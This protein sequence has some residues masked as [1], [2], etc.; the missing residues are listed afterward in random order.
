MPTRRNAA[1]PARIAPRAA[2]GPP[3]FDRLDRRRRATDELGD[4]PSRHDHRVHA[5]TLQLDHLIARHGFR[6]R[7]RELSDRHVREQFERAL[8]IVRR[9]MKRLGVVPL[10]HASE[11]LLAADADDD[12]EPEVGCVRG[13]GVEP[14]SVLVVPLGDHEQRIRSRTI[15]IVGRPAAAPEDWQLGC[16]AD[17]CEGRPQDD[18]LGTVCLC[19]SCG[20]GRVDF[21]DHR[22]SVSLGYR[23]TKSSAAPLGQE[24]GSYRLRYRES[25]RVSPAF[26]LVIFALFVPAVATAAVIQGTARPDRLKGT[27]KAD[28]ID[29]VFGATDRVTCGKGVDV[30]TAD[31]ADTVARDCEFVSRRISTDT[32][33]ASAGQHQTE[34]EPSVAGWGSTAV[35]TFQVGRFTDGGATGIGWSTST[36]AG[37]TWRSGVLPALTSA[38]HPAG[39]APRASDPAVAYDAVHGTWLI[40][41]LVL[42]NGFTALGISRSVDG[43]SWSA[44]V[45]AARLSTSSLAYDKEWISCDNGPTSPFHGSCYLVYTDIASPRIALQVSRDGGATWS[46]PVTVTSAF[47]AGAEG[48]LPIVQPN[49]ALTLVFNAGDAGMYAV[50]STDGGATFAPPVGIAPISEAS[51]PLLR[52]PALPT[53][54]VDISGRIYVVWADCVFRP[55]CDGNTLVLTTSTDGSTWTGLRRLPGTGFDSFVPGLA[56]DPSMPGRLSIVTYV[57]NSTACSAATCSIG[58]AVTGSRDGGTSWSKPQRLDAVSPRTAWLAIAERQFVGDYVGAAF[59]AGRFVPV[60]ALASKPLSGG[61]LREY[62]MAASLS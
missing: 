5:A 4:V 61:R 26:T 30:V 53:A 55:G 62:M 19:G 6:F 39:E 51:Q 20:V 1:A 10:E 23:L 24:C 56:A 45:F 17:A 28:R 9:E 29:A 47:G 43:L 48:A 58:V 16:V 36:D 59:V 60:F 35:A 32:L 3:Q 8:K 15:R 25:V 2:C 37:R 44:P 40:S 33:S 38:S 27:A 46:A 11:H 14:V 42:G 57:R 54:A 31:P 34:V 22:D 41:T 49:G 21:D 52:A 50:H 12:V 13:D 18:S 7:D